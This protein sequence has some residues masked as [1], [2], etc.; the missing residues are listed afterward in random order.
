MISNKDRKL[1]FIEAGIVI[2]LVYL[3]IMG[4]TYVLDEFRIK[5]LDKQVQIY[6][7]KHESFLAMNSFYDAEGKTNCEFSKKYIF[8]EYEEI[9]ELSTD[10]SSFKNRILSSS[11][12]KHN[13][14]KRQFLMAQAENFNKISLHN[15]LCENKIYPI[16]Y[17]I[18][19]DLTG[20]N[21]QALLLQQFSLSHKNEIIIHI[22]DINY[23]DEI[24]IKLLLNLYQ[25][26][27]HNTVIFG[28]LSNKEGNPIG[29]Y[30]LNEELTRLR[31][32]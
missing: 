11:E 16:F 9:K 28:N 25:I 7:L 13:I 2:I 29:I 1:I 6:T 5:E 30:Q 17:F 18:D 3:F 4:L 32:I 31:G 12:S 10:L 22:L 24:I 19:G 15:E 27:N 26:E 23:K 8:Q 21:Q 14:K 20:F